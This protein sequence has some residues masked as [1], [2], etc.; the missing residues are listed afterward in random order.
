MAHKE[1]Y[2]TRDPEAHWAGLVVT[3]I[4]LA[5]LVVF[6]EDYFSGAMGSG[7]RENGVGIMEGRVPSNQQE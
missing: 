5:A 2:V 4:I 6:G 3:A 7:A 1:I